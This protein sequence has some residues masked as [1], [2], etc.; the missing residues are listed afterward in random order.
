[1]ADQF[2]PQQGAGDGRT[3]DARARVRVGPHPRLQ[4][5]AAARRLHGDL[6]FVGQHLEGARRA[7]RSAAVEHAVHAD[8]DRRRVEFA[9]AEA[10]RDRCRDRQRTVQFAK[11]RRDALLDRLGD[12]HVGEL[13]PELP[14]RIRRRHRA[15]EREIVG[16][17]RLEASVVADRHPDEVVVGVDP[18]GG[19]RVRP[20][21][22]ERIDRRA[23]RGE[24]L[25]KLLDLEPGAHR[26]RIEPRA[27]MVG[28][29]PGDDDAVAGVADEARKQPIRIRDAAALGKCRESGGDVG[30]RQAVDR[31]RPAEPRRLEAG[32]A[33]HPR[34]RRIACRRREHRGRRRDRQRWKEGHCGKDGRS[35]HRDRSHVVDS[36]SRNSSGATGLRR[37]SRRR[38][39]RHEAL[40]GNRSIARGIP[41]QR[42]IPDQGRGFPLLGCT[43]RRSRN[44]PASDSPA[45]GCVVP[46]RCG[47]RA[48]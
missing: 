26:S 38:L 41:A 23:A 8:R 43:K 45:S 44:L 20:A 46:S 29:A 35:A 2:V 21:K 4:H 34:D 31:K 9:S 19:K 3:L 12:L 14:L 40:V 47:T 7:A 33:D 6:E 32:V 28:D 24:L 17:D 13:V 27:V 18:L 5:A 16:R 22:Q 10:D 39:R 36:C 25:R 37:E 30:R 48:S 1:M 11:R 15:R 42:S